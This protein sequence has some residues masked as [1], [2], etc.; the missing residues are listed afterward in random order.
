MQSAVDY[1][2]SP[3]EYLKGVGPAKAELLKTELEIFTFRDLLLTYPFRHIDRSM[4]LPISQITEDNSTV[5]VKGRLG[6]LVLSGSRFQRRINSTLTDNS[7]VLSLI[8]FNGASWLEKSLK[9]GEEYVMYGKVTY[10][11]YKY[12]M[13][14]PEMEA[15]SE[16]SRLPGL[17]AVY[18]STEKI[19]SKGL[20]S[21]ARR[22]CIATMF[23]RLTP[24]LLPET[25]PSYIIQ[26][27]KLCSYFESMH[28][29]HMPPSLRH[30]EEATYRIKFEELFFQQISLLSSKEFHKKHVSGP[31]FKSVGDLF[32]AFYHEHLKFELTGAQK[33]V[34]KEIRSDTGSGAQMNRLLQGDVGSGKTIV[35]L[36]IMLL[37]IDNGFQACIMAPTEILAQQHFASVTNAL[38]GMTLPIG[39]LTG[40]IKGKKRE[41]LL[42]SLFEGEIKIL[43][44]TH[45]LLEDP[46]QFKNLGL[47]VIDEQ[48]R[49]GVAQRANLW[50]KNQ[51]VAPH[52][53]VMTATPIPRT[54]SMVY[55]G[56]LDISIIDELP[57]GRKPIKTMHFFEKSRPQLHQFIRSQIQAGRQVYF[58][59]PLIEESEKLALQDLQNGYEILLHHFPKPTYQISV[60]H[61]RMKSEVKDEEMKRFKE[62]R[63][64]ILVSTTVIEVG[65]DVPNASIMV[66]ENAE[67]FGLSQLHQLRGRVGR[68]ADQS[69]CVLMT[70]FKLST[71]ARIRIQTM[72]ETTDGFKIAEVDLELRGPGDISGTRQSG[73]EEFNLVNLSSDLKILEEVQNL[74]QKI[75]ERDSGL[76]HP[77]NQLLFNHVH[78]VQKS[79]PIWAKIS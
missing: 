63:T 13:A 64:Q 41:S 65:V 75:L 56:D 69:Y 22:K 55:Y 28:W 25:L 47:A 79:K 20:D 49:F 34:I 3:I 8:W 36:M 54:L 1:L 78:S 44:G 68:G 60:L 11:G 57:P 7:G 33:K 38:T 40:S 31:V 18:N 52:I 58:V 59:Y 6:K 15:A 9:P 66:I 4:I 35:A 74:V 50:Q 29:I 72:C 23:E 12:T 67:R 5:Q 39:I 53:L 51:T 17:E 30:V 73:G 45:A 71:Q 27:K 42:K 70:G 14:H 19:N 76:I 16:V 10:S 32:N 46:V 24:A 37:A 48:H 43:I 26:R 62:Q 61:G 21:K 2:D 77:E